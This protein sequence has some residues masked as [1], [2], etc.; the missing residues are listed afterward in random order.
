V[1]VVR[2]SL[3]ELQPEK[4]Q[5]FYLG[6]AMGYDFSNKDLLALQCCNTELAQLPEL[7]EGFPT[8]YIPRIL[9][10]RPADL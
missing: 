4:F 6:F 10:R 9:V 7:H 8:L 3:L 5:G 2:H 1:A